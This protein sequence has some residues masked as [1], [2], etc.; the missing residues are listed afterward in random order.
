[1]YG[2]SAR[3]AHAGGSCTNHFRVRI[4]SV[5]G[6][7]RDEHR[8]DEGPLGGARQQV[9]FTGSWKP[10]NAT[11][12]EAGKAG[13]T[14]GGWKNSLRPCT[15]RR[16]GEVGKTVWGAT[17]VAMLGF[18]KREDSRPLQAAGR[19]GNCAI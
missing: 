15:W 19:L 4:D 12:F 10:Q 16:T 9:G 18:W 6:R 1:M 3:L 2:G 13:G 17:H 7:A 11:S 14:A 8:I 5:G